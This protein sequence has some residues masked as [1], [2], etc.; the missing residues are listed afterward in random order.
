MLFELL[1]MI[2][3]NRVFPVR[4]LILAVGCGL[5]LGLAAGCGRQAAKEPVPD[6]QAVLQQNDRATEFVGVGNELRRKG[7]L[8]SAAEMYSRA[9]RAD[10]KSPLPP[11][12]LGDTLRRLKR[13][14]ESEKV[15]AQALS[16]NPYSGLALQ[17][18][19]ILMIEKGQPEAAV[20]ALTNAVD[21]EAADYRV[22]NVLGIAYDSLGD[23]TQAQTFYTAGLGQAPDNASLRN[24]MALSLALQERYDAAIDQ[25]KQLASAADG[26]EAYRHNLALIY[27]LAGRIEDAAG[28]TGR[29]VAAADVAN[30]LAYY[31]SLRA[32]EPDKRRAAILDVVLRSL[33]LKDSEIVADSQSQ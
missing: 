25:M 4:R 1:T 20:G 31:Q 6:D 5:L 19:G 32:M 10:P 22:Y 24:N 27:G 13:Y 15:F 23:H 3:H 7:D 16:E 30:N 33:F 21:E 14:N 17:G 29:S 11:A 26:Q 28:R 12:L 2:R 9:M 8:V 18:Y